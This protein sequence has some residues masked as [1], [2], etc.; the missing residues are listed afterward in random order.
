MHLFSASKEHCMEV[1]DKIEKMGVEY[2]FPVHCT[3]MNAIIDFKIRLGDK[4]KI[5][6]AGDAFVV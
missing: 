6:M 3:G 1:I 4:V 5:A 2:I